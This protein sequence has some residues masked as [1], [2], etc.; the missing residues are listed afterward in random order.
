MIIKHLE[1]ILSEHKKAVEKSF[2][3]TKLE[4]LDLIARELLRAF[5]GNHKVLLCGNGGSAADAQH[6]AAEFIGRFKRERKSLPALALT[7]DTSI[8]TALANDYNYNLI[9]ARQIEGLGQ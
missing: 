3:T 1:N 9:F 8:I 4:V 7:T 5:K 6:I 2:Q